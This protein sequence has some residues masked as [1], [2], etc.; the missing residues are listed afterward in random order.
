MKKSLFIVLLV[1]CCMNV[2]AQQAHPVLSDSLVTDSVAKID[3]LSVVRH[4]VVV[5][6]KQPSRVNLKLPSPSG[7]KPVRRMDRQMVES[8]GEV[9]RNVLNK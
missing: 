4:S 3:S 2:K 6:G 8:Y 1:S 9:I 7:Y 5:T